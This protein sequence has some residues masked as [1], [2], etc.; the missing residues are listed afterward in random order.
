MT[1]IRYTFT[2]YL[3]Y[4]YQSIYLPYSC[5][6]GKAGTAWTIYRII[7]PSLTRDLLINRIDSDYLN[8]MFD[9][10]Q[11]MCSSAASMAKKS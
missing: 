11:K 6:S 9:N 3:D 8:E 7:F 2:E 4:W 5:G 10:C 1:D